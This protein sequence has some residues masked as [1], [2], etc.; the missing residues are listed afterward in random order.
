MRQD[1]EVLDRLCGGMVE[2]RVGTLGHVR[3]KLALAELFCGTTNSG[4]SAP[5]R[6]AP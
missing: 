4:I 1:D 2:R 5:S 3:A 6:T